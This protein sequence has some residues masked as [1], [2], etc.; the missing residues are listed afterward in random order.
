[1]PEAMIS[2]IKEWKRSRNAKVGQIPQTYSGPSSCPDTCP[3]RDGGCYGKVVHPTGGPSVWGRQQKAEMARLAGEDVLIYTPEELADV[4][5]GK[6]R[7][8]AGTAPLSIS[9]WKRGTIPGLWRMNICGDLPGDG[10]RINWEALDVIVGANSEAGLKGFSYSHYYSEGSQDKPF[11]SDDNLDVI[12]AAN[13][14]GFTISLSA[15]NMGELDDLAEITEGELPL[16]V[17]APSWLGKY[18]RGKKEGQWISRKG[19]NFHSP[20]GQKIRYCQAVVKDNISCANCGWC[21]QRDRDFAVLFPAHGAQSKCV[22]YYIVNEEEGWSALYDL[23]SDPGEHHDR[24][25]DEAARAAALS[26]QLERFGDDV[27]THTGA[28]STTVE[29]DDE[30]RE[31]LEALGYVE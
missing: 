2:F 15:D 25:S 1:M 13:E 24:S 16:A 26:A 3:W 17:V 11:V 8:R 23:A 21:Q 19:T 10:Q 30:L 6:T 9:Q 12:L 27:A 20:K 14:A 29:L 7:Y 18:G 31:R 4:L 28:P 5:T 22:D